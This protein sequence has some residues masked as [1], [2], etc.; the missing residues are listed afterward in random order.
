MP[1]NNVPVRRNASVDAG[2]DRA[3]GDRNLA[4]MVRIG[5]VSALG[6]MTFPVCGAEHCVSGTVGGGCTSSATPTTFP[7]S[8]DGSD[9]ET[10]DPKREAQVVAPGDYRI[11]FENQ[12]IRVQWVTVRAGAEEPMLDHPL[13]AILVVEPGISPADLVQRDVNGK[14]VGFG[15]VDA[16]QAPLVGVQPPQALHSVKNI[17]PTDG[18]LIR[19]EFK[20][21]IPKLLHPKWTTETMPI[22]TDGTDPKTW[23]PAMD[24]PSAA[25][26]NHKIIF[27]NDT[28][29]LQSV[30]V[31][32]MSEEHYHDHPYPSVLVPDQA[33]PKELDRNRAGEE[34]DLSA[35]AGL[36][37]YAF[38]QPP[39]G[40]HSVK[41]LSAT[42]D[43]LIRIEFKQ[44]LP[45][46]WGK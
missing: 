24:G 10:W 46:S 8:T 22:S 23:N 12:N 15:F 1:R 30:T 5:A 45:A 21:G 31:S 11:I 13:P 38:V 9:P 27:E 3:K 42:P 26:A 28:L 25:P 18:H 20:R 44:G 41:N 16:I 32:P 39:E 29:R 43:H 37:P 17:G 35:L 6:L 33:P 4:G 19:I 7:L 14:S 40:L 34:F 36:A 2:G